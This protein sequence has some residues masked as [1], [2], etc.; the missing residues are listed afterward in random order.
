MENAWRESMTA[1]NVL[2]GRKWSLQRA[3]TL[4]AAFSLFVPKTLLALDEVVF[5]EKILKVIPWGKGEGK[6]GR[7]I[8]GGINP[9]YGAVGNVFVLGEKMYIGDRNDGAAIV[10]DLNSGAVS[11]IGPNL[12]NSSKAGDIVYRGDDRKS[13]YFLSQDKVEEVGLNGKRVSVGI[14]KDRLFNLLWKRGDF[15]RGIYKDKKPRLSPKRRFP[16]KELSLSDVEVEDFNDFIA[17]QRWDSKKHV[18]TINLYPSKGISTC[19][20]IT[21]KSSVGLLAGVLLDRDEKGTMFF[22]TKQLGNDKDSPYCWITM[23]DLSACQI[24]FIRLYKILP[25]GNNSAV[26]V[27]SSI[28]G[29][30]IYQVESAANGVTISEWRQSES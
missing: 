3:L 7:K 10:F 27:G 21:A 2:L 26:A 4:L 20:T 23:L 6:I 19:G 16:G 1:K 25:D 8:I 9:G 12:A 18:Q 17:P 14:S 24:K 5:Q 15:S 28:S 11:K 29:P 22:H 30:V 13:V